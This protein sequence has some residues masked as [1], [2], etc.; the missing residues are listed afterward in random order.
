MSPPPVSKEERREQIMQAAITCFSRKGYHLTTMDDIVV[1]SGLS[2]GSLYWH[3]K[4]KKDLLLSIANW[5]FSHIINGLEAA[6]QSAPTVMDKLKISL[7]AFT[8]ILI[9]PDPIFNVFIDFYAE[10]RHDKELETILKDMMLPF[11]DSIAALI[12]EGVDN[13]ELK[14][15][16]A[17]QVSVSLMAAFDGLL[18]YEMMLP[19]EFDWVE[20][21]HLFSGIILDGLRAQ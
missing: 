13:G 4:N 15:V 12:Q 7:D 1:E 17:R 16:N 9:S 6:I 21:G 11:V 3:Y 19:D 14:S 2:K 18:L 20:T 5:Y 8:Q 10:T